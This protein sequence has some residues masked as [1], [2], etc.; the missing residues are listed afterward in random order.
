MSNPENHTIFRER[1]APLLFKLKGVCTELGI[2]MLAAFSL[3]DDERAVAV[4]QPPKKDIKELSVLILT[5]IHVVDGIENEQEPGSD[6][7]H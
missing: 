4:Y 5:L 7:V 2:P 6:T 3:G 1:I